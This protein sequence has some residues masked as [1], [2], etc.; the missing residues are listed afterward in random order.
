MI[1]AQHIS[2]AIRHQRLTGGVDHL[3]PIPVLF[4]FQGL[5][6]STKVC[7]PSA[8]ECTPCF[9]SEIFVRFT[10]LLCGATSELKA[11]FNRFFKNRLFSDPKA[12]QT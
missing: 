3:S 7:N 8:G 11:P 6:V 5:N 10:F 9:W 2:A 1:I 12:Q 4:F